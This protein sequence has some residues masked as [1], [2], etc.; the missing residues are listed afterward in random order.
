MMEAPDLNTYSAIE[1]AA[2][3]NEL[4]VQGRFSISDLKY[5]VDEVVNAINQTAGIEVSEAET[6][7]PAE[8]SPSNPNDYTPMTGPTPE[9]I[10]AAESHEAV[11]YMAENFFYLIT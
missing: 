1:A 2:E 6:I 5:N 7:G 10:S 3:S 11:E 9:E 4:S 8:V